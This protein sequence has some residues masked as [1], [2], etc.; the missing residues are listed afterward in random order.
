MTIKNR[1]KAF[2]FAFSG[3]KFLL[4]DEVHARFHLVATIIVISL[5]FAFKVS[6]I[7]WAI[8]LICMALVW[9]M[10]AANSAIENLTDLVTKEKHPLAKNA[11]D[12]G[13]AA[14]LLAA[15]FSAIIGAIIFIPKML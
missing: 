7:E 4:K 5:G 14:V 1:I 6:P 8:L 11:K 12:L 2:Y 3:V 15:I 13:A 10:E 9:S